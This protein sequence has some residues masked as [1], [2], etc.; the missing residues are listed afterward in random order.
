MFGEYSTRW[1][2]TTLISR[3]MH[4]TGVSVLHLTHK[5]MQRERE[6]ERA[7]RAVRYAS[8]LTFDPTVGGVQ[9]L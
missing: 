2:A 7:V 1:S 3:H 9:K 4:T 5:H 8:P 6:R